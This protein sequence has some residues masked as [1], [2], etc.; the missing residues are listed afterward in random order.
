M[1][2]ATRRGANAVI[3]T[4][5]RKQGLNVGIAKLS[6]QRNFPLQRG[7]VLPPGSLH[8]KFAAFGDEGLP[9]ILLCPSMSNSPFPIDVPELGEAGWWNRVVGYGANYGIQLDQF[10]VIVPS[11]L[12]SP[13]G[14]TSPLSLKPRVSSAQ[15]DEQE[16]EDSAQEQPGTADRWGP[17][18]PIITPADMADVHS[19]LLDVLEI[20]KL[21]AVIGGSM[22]G[23]QAS[24]A[25]GTFVWCC[26]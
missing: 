4:L 19:R 10:R 24:V 5:L 9:A 23:M 22:G 16:E 11:P 12:G 25:T 18:F 3:E 14:S 7:G 2:T 20:P 17:D 8:V 15:G 26:L 1:A 21:H 6:Q 13:F